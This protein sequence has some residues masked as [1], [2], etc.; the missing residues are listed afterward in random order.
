[1]QK[2]ESIETKEAVETKPAKPPKNKKMDLLSH[3]EQIIKLSAGSGFNDEFF[4]KARQHINAVK[5][6]LKINDIQAALFAHFLNRCDSTISLNGIANSIGSEQIRVLQYMNE[7]EE[8]EKRRMVRRHQHDFYPSYSV[9]RGVIEAVRHNKA[10]HPPSRKNLSIEALFDVLNQLFQELRKNVLTFDLFVYEIKALFAENQQLGFTQKLEQFKFI[11]SDEKQSLDNGFPYFSEEDY[12]LLLRF[13]NLFVEE[14]RDNIY[15][16]DIN[17]CFPERNTY[18]IQW[19][20]AHKTNLLFK[21]GLIENTNEDGFAIRETYRLTDKAKTELLGE[22]NIIQ[23]QAKTQRDITLYTSI[24]SKQMYYNEKEQHQVAELTAL[25][26]EENFNKVTQRLT[27]KGMRTGFACLFH[28]AP[29]TGKTETVYQIARQTE[30]NI[31]QVDISNTKSMWFGESEKCIKG[32]FLRYRALLKTE[33]IAPILLFNE[34]DAVIG[35]RKDVTSGNIA[36]TENAIQNII[37]QEMETLDGIMIATTNLTQ[38]LDKAFERRF[39]Y[40]IEFGKPNTD[41][42]RAIWKTTIPELSE[43]DATTLANRYDFSGGQIENIARKAAIDSI[44][45][46]KEPDLAKLEFHC[47]S[48]SLINGRRA[49]GF[50]A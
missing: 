33:K 50:A 46:G 26:Q 32:I 17:D 18:S 13:C 25:L 30:R 23:K 36:Q 1:M 3:F 6:I 12:V 35:K 5:K 22:L 48:E 42:K 31:Y 40:K 39:L 44:I 24:A 2:T 9:P 43:A 19:S 28:G 11:E 15:F 10:Y 8:L 27:D 4:H 47:K 41:A 7:I 21:E 37:L 34:A 16:S 29:G 45:C 14:E 49:I 38:N 20:L